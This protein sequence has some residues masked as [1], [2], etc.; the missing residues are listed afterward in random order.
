MTFPVGGYTDTASA[1]VD[2]LVA[3]LNFNELSGD[4]KDDWMPAAYFDCYATGYEGDGTQIAAGMWGNALR[5]SGNGGIGNWHALDINNTGT[6]T[7]FSVS[8]WMKFETGEV[9]ATGTRL[10]W[11][12]E[13]DGD[14]NGQEFYMK[15]DNSTGYLI[16]YFGDWSDGATY[17]YNTNIKDDT[18]HLHNIVRDGNTLTW[19]IDGASV[20]TLTDAVDVGGITFFAYYDTEW[21]SNRTNVV[22]DDFGLWGRALGATDISRL[23]NG[24]SG[25]S[26]EYLEV[27]PYSRVLEETM[28]QVD[29]D[30]YYMAVENF[31]VEENLGG[32]EWLSF[33]TPYAH[34]FLVETGMNFSDVLHPAE[35]IELVESLEQSDLISY[36]WHILKVIS[37]SLEVV[38]DLPAPPYAY[39]M[40]ETLLAASTPTAIGIFERG[41]TEELTMSDLYAIAWHKGLSEMINGSDS[42]E[43]LRRLVAS[44]VETMYSA[45]VA[46][47]NRISDEVC[48]EALSLADACLRFFEMMAAE[49]MSIAHTQVVEAKFGNELVEALEAADSVSDNYGFSV[50][51]N[52]EFTASDDATAGA[53]LNHIIEEGMAFLN[54]TPVI[55]GGT[56]TGWVMNPETFSVWNYEN[57]NFNSFSAANGEVYGAATDGIYTMDSTT[58]DGVS[59]ESRLTTAAIDFGT[60]NLKQVPQVYL[61]M[62][63][64][65][66]IV[67]KVKVDNKADVW[68]EATPVES[69]EHT[70]MVKLGKGLVGRNWQFSLVTKDNSSIDIESLEF[71]PVVFKR[72]R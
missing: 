58:D 34:E 29:A 56:Y 54:I 70:H 19:Y 15:V 5:F 16:L 3:Y 31:L 14:Y 62:T 64:D 69:Y 40:A 71:Y 33:S 65:G 47:A 68:Y 26:I 32:S 61:G 38:D 17:N 18:W 53:I 25:T 7:D 60:K 59:I 45:D 21:G 48:T 44:L 49:S 35:V 13:D 67:L 52:E 43:N 66:T 63:S 51:I 39:L 11:I 28:D 20:A 10:V 9:G 42:T 55:N 24:G 37:E 57:Y 30:E 46:T 23:W 22:I 50:V 1:G 72:K 2:S 6:Y 12:F 27:S 41:L 8:T 4:D 36:T